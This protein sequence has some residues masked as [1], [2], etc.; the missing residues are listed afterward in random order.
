MST[1]LEILSFPLSLRGLLGRES[2]RQSRVESAS[3]PRRS[4]PPQLH[5]GPS[6]PP[7]EPR[8]AASC[9]LEWC[10]GAESSTHRR[11]AVASVFAGRIG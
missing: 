5:R 11:I 2:G 8:A 7:P 3:P 6:D 4:T 9:K 10:T 1:V